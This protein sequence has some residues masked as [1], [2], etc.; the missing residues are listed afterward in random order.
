MLAGMASKS[1]P[2]ARK[3]S[4]R[5]GL[6]EANTN[7]SL[8]NSSTEMTSCLA[9]SQMFVKLTAAYKSAKFAASGVKSQTEEL[10]LEQLIKSLPAVLRAAENSEEVYRAA[11][12]A[13]WKHSVGE[14]LR[15]NA[16][17]LRYHHHRLTIA[18]VDAIWQKQ[19]QPMVDQLI[20][21]LNSVLGQRLIRTIEFVVTPD[22]VATILEREQPKTAQ[23]E[24]HESPP[25]VISAAANISDV[26]LRRAFL[27]AASSCLA[28][29]KKANNAD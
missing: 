3:I 14:A 22:A 2:T 7:F 5:R 11:C 19:L 6:R 25:E 21:R 10:R 28:R 8:C 13:A 12:V 1:Q 16:V 15:S 17:V 24:L 26:K 29:N 23:S 27:A 4:V 18:V 20:Y 9:H